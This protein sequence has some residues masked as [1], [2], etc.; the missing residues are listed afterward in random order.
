MFVTFSSSFWSL[1]M[2]SPT[3]NMPLL[4]AANEP[5]V[6]SLKFAS[7]DM[8]ELSFCFDKVSSEIV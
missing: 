8:G 3:H 2:K 6:A 5:F 4:Y 1:S 7:N